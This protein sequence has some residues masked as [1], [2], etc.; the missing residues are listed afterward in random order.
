MPLRKNNRVVK[1][2]ECLLSLGSNVGNR[3][4]HLQ[5]AILSIGKIAGVKVLKKSRIYQTEPLGPSRRK[6]LNCALK[7]KTTRSAMGLLIEFKRLE[8]LAGRKP[9]LRWGPRPLDIDL[10]AYGDAKVKTAWLK[11]PHPQAARRAFVLVPLFEIAPKAKLHSGETV[12][13]AFSRLKGISQSV[14][15]F[16]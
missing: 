1:A 5:R 11:I 3:T 14:K 16:S 12:Q 8:A 7:I 15:L 10:I 2:V 6:F 9:G 13:E 4:S